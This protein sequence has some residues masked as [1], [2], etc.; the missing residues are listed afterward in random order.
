MSDYPLSSAKEAG[1]ISFVVDPFLCVLVGGLLTFDLSTYATVSTT[2]QS[3][4]HLYYNH[5]I[6]FVCLTLSLV[7]VVVVV[8]F[9]MTGRSRITNTSVGFFPFSD[10]WIERMRFSVRKRF[11]QTLC[12]Y[13]MTIKVGNTGSLHYIGLRAELSRADFF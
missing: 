6:N 9:W 1:S 12:V 3:E 7:V 5:E 13:Y 2:I 4:N 10:S 11:S 8:M